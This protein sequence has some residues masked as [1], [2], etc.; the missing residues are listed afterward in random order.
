MRNKVPDKSSRKRCCTIVWP[1]HFVRNKVPDKSSRKRFKL[2]LD[3]PGNVL[4]KSA[5][6]KCCQSET[7]GDLVTNSLKLFNCIWHIQGH[8][9]CQKAFS[10]YYHVLSVL[11]CWGPR[12]KPFSQVD[13]INLI[14]WTSIPFQWYEHF[15]GWGLGQLR[16]RFVDIF[17]NLIV[18]KLIW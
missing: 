17:S 4:Q 16:V 12:V 8:F 14:G 18:F 6:K 1:Y 13:R 5:K 15:C 10:I 7:F 2:S 9:N 11:S 3:D